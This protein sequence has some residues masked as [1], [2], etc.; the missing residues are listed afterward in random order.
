MRRKYWIWLSFA[1]C[2]K[3]VEGSLLEAASPA[4]RPQLRTVSIPST[5]DGKGQPVR[6]WI[7]ASLDKPAPILV[8]L[9]TWSSDYRQDRTPWVKEAMQRN[10]IYL[11]PNFRGRNDHPEACG[12]ALAR[13]DILDA[14]DWAMKSFPVDSSRVYLAGV[15]GGG[16]MTMLMAGYHPDRFSA[17]SAWVGISDLAD[18][19]RFHS[20]DGKPDKYARM[21]A[22]STG[23]PP[24]ES[25]M[26]DREYHDRSPIHVLHRVGNLSLD[27]NAGVHDGKSGSVPIHHTLR[28]F[29]VIAQA[30]KNALIPE[31]EMDLLWHEQR[32]ANPLPSDSQADP[33]YQRKIYLRRFSGKTRVT[34]FE[35]GHEALPHAACLWLESKV[36][37]TKPPSQ[38]PAPSTNKGK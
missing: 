37:E 28:A 30:R 22:A 24:G 7:P 3:L 25:P 33:S 9:H 4:A 20:R 15:S 23:G 11:Q 36:R 26:V 32:L 27:L 21:I 35:G 13:Q 1:L 34:I 6:Y 14:L 38:S 17:A 16:H 29:N 2:L 12:S 19:Y 31:S 10:W 8:S 18:W 5:L